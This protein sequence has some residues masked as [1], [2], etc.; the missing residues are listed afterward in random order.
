[1]T[2]SYIQHPGM[3]IEEAIRDQYPTKDGW[4]CP[5]CKNYKG[6][7]ICEK[8]IFIAFVRANMSGCKFYE[9]GGIC[10]H[11]GGI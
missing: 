2:T 4:I 3:T 5:S 11:Y 6:S 8:G 10:K 9:R 7:L 1:M